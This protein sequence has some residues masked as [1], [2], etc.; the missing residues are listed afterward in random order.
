MLSCCLDK[1]TH[2]S[3]IH[4]HVKPIRIIVGGV[5]IKGA[6]NDSP[7]A[8]KI[9]QLLPYDEVG[10]T[11]GQELYFPVRLAV[12][13]PEPVEQVKVG[14]IA[15]WPDGPDLCLF[16]GR[17]PKSTDDTPVVAS[18]VTIVGS[19]EYNPQ[20]FHFF[21][22]EKSGIPVRIEPRMPDAGTGQ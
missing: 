3:T 17:T 1:Q 21:R 15:Y 6:L 16:F 10:E 11:W 18:P 8:E 5:E 14:D 12:E 13:N 9:W 19:F 22:R 7:L 2:F 20:D 4:P